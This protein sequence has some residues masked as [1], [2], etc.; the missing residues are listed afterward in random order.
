MSCCGA[1]RA[2]QRVQSIAQPHPAPHGR[3]GSSASIRSVSFEYTGL[4]PLVVTGPATGAKYRFDRQ[5]I[6]Q[7]VHGADAPSLLHVPNLR[8]VR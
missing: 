1:N 8:P 7:L 6:R 2:A 5:G 3:S 4:S